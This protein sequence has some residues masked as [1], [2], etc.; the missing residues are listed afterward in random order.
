MALDPD[1][2]RP[3]YV[4]VANA[5]RAAIL[6]KKFTAGDKLPSRNELA[7]TYNVA[8]MTVQN[9]LR[10]LRD[11]GLIVSRQGSGVF[12]RERTER[13]VGLR[14]HIERAFEAE[15]VTV[16]FAGFSG[17]TLHGAMQE[18]LDKIRAGRLRPESLTV[19]ILIPD[20]TAPL[21]IPCRVEDLG[22]SPEFRAR[23]TA[24]MHRHVG[25]ITDTVN[26]LGSLGIVNKA[27]ATVRVHHA[28]PLF[29]LYIVNNEEAFFGFYPV[30][31]HILTFGETP[32]PIYDLMGKDAILFHHSTTDDDTSTGSQYVDQA[33]TW[34][35]SMWGTV[36]KE[37]I[38]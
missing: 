19:R 36:S 25:A 17:E 13:P 8:P 23:A 21:A 29:K 10:E 11:E 27:T 12:V 20:T 1:D 37:F 38:P 3:P 2:P 26:E 30:R 9:A 24:I 18:P 16:D 15:H 6:T 4:Q 7:K 35:D 22:D 5:L 34:F 14:P 28:A 31:E 33:R 32:T